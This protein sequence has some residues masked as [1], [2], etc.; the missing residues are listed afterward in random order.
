[1]RQL[2]SIVVVLPLCIAA[3]PGCAARGDLSEMDFHSVPVCDDSTIGVTVTGLMNDASISEYHSR[4]VALRWIPNAQSYSVVPVPD[5]PRLQN[6]RDVQ[7]TLRTVYPRSLRSQ[8]IGGTATFWY[9]L[10]S[11]G[12]VTHVQLKEGAGHEELN[13]AAAQALA[14]FRFSA[15]VTSDCRLQHYFSSTRVTLDASL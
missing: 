14:T 7:H 1:M 8:G 5:R 11:D 4:L 9:L 3:L 12:N 10:D 13:A 2:V 6:A 15:P